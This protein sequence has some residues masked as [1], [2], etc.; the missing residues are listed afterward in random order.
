MDRCR[1]LHISVKGLEQ[2]D[3]FRWNFEEYCLVF[4]F[5]FFVPFAILVFQWCSNS[6]FSFCRIFIYEVSYFFA[7]LFGFGYLCGYA[8]IS[9]AAEVKSL[10]IAV[11]CSSHPPSLLLTVP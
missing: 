5:F 6:R 4:L 9:A 1:V 7:Y 8:A 10:L 3:I 11:H 2:T